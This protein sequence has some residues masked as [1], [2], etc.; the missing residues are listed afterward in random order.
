MRRRCVLTQ[1]SR[2][3][4]SWGPCCTH[5]E[6]T[7]GKGTENS[8]RVT[9]GTGVCPDLWMSE[10]KEAKARAGPEDGMRRSE[11]GERRDGAGRLNGRSKLIR[12][13]PRALLKFPV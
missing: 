3:L 1:P 11:V 7:V 12:R 5:A 6:K 2:P 4:G 9:L 10:A 8:P 13:R